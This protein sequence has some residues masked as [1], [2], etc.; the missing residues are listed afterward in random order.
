MANFAQ[1]AGSLSLQTASVSRSEENRCNFRQARHLD[2]SKS[3]TE[4]IKPAD[5]AMIQFRL[6][7][8]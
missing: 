4:K 3:W 1:P 8:W 6:D 5:D 2:L 7:F